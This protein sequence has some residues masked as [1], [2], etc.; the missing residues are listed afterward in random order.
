MNEFLAE[1]DFAMEEIVRNYGALIKGAVYKSMGGDPGR[2][3]ILSEIYFAIFLNLRKFGAGWTP[4]RSF[5]Y[6]VIRN[7]VNDF[8]R[9]KYREKNRIDEIQKHV[10]EQALQRE[11]VVSKIHCLSHCEFQ[12]FRLL[13]QGMTN[14][15]LAL[16]LHVSLATIRSHLKKIYAKCGLRDRGKLTLIAHHACFRDFSEAIEGRAS[17]DAVCRPAGQVS[18][19]HSMTQN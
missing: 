6:A 2:D 15:E 17:Y 4:P 19:A 3:D 5:F 7:K 13:G 9:R 10:A 8:L 18:A 11:E 12:V 1:H 16:S 14:E